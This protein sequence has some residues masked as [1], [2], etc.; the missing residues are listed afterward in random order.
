MRSRIW[1]E[2][3]WNV[4]QFS[5]FFSVS[6][7]Q[8]SWQKQSAVHTMES[9]YH[10][11]S[12]TSRYAKSVKIMAFPGWRNL[13][14]LCLFVLNSEI[15]VFNYSTTQTF[16]N[17]KLYLSKIRFSWL[18]VVAWWFLF[19]VF[20]SYFHYLNICPLSLLPFDSAHFLFLKCLQ[21]AF[22]CLSGF[23]WMRFW[24]TMFSCEVFKSIFCEFRWI[25]MLFLLSWMSDN[26]ENLIEIV[27]CRLKYMCTICKFTR[28]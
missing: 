3:Y 12:H 8:W 16:P 11:S 4:Y 7:S 5:Y 2:K 20:H 24:T 1:N 28:T 19:S 10:I 18:V 15:I 6:T 23:L 22:N 26:F 9:L 14:I 27:R 17:C 13:N 21:I 25:H